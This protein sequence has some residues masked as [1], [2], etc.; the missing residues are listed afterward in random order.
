MIDS[1]YVLITPARNEEAFIE[2]TIE[3][4]I[5]QTLLPLRWVIVNDGSTD[6]TASKIRPYIA[7]HP[8]IRLV[9]LPVRRERHFAAK[10][11]AFN[12][13][14][15]Q[16]KDLTYDV[17]GNLDA[18]V[19]IE[20]DHFEF[21]MNEFKK[22][23]SLGVAGTIFKEEGYSSD[24]DSYEG[25]KHVAGAC[26]LFRHRCFEEI[27]G[28]CPNKAGGVDWIAVTSARMKGWKTRSFR[29]RSLFHYRK[30]GTAERGHLASSFSYGEKDYYLGG[31]PVW[32]LFRV[33]FRMT[34][35]PYLVV[36]AALGLGY[37]WAFVSR[38]QRP[39]SRDLMRFHRKE[40]MQKLRAILGS[41]LRRRRLNSFQTISTSENR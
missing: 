8:W 23:P 31:H 15:E 26:Q 14:K 13:G 38:Q 29:E 9:D 7:D 40:Q 35:S 16:L 17:I 36:G 3:S 39:V 30:L 28:Y 4:V 1:P 32:E 10:V 21:L 22:D 2:R 37:L 19:S 6:Q 5:K 11:Y 33:A 41:L 20:E 12:A 27:G 34:K 18:D 25:E 24:T